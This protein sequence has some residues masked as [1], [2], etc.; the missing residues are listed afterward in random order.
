MLKTINFPLY[1]GKTVSDGIIEGSLVIELDH[2]ED[3]IDEIF[4]QE[5]KHYYDDGVACLSIDEDTLEVSQ[6]NEVD[7]NGDRIFKPVICRLS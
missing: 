3:G 2:H 5:I 1:R 4:I 7:E 6:P